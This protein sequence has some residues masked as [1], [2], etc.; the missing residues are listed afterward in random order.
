MLW[1]CWQFFCARSWACWS[2]KK[3]LHLGLIKGLIMEMSMRAKIPSKAKGIARITSITT[4]GPIT[5]FP[6]LL[7]RRIRNH[8]V[9]VK[10]MRAFHPNPD[11]RSGK[12]WFEKAWSEL[13]AASLTFSPLSAGRISSIS[14]V[15]VLGISA[16]AGVI[17]GRVF[18]PFG[19]R[20]SQSV[21]GVTMDLYGRWGGR[22]GC[23][24]ARQRGSSLLF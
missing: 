5:H 6:Q 8:W 18:Y 20:W 11:A 16:G 15:F 21:R 22:C 1:W 3:G 4:T 12:G 7:L 17:F 10:V 14:M 24:Q 2:F 9:S 13:E 19:H 23:V